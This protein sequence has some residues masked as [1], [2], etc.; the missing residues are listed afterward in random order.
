MRISQRSEGNSLV[1][2]DCERANVLVIRNGSGGRGPVPVGLKAGERGK[3]PG[4]RARN[5][6]E[7]EAVMEVID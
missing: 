5:S 1:H 2:N 6:Q 4:R 3:S 7:R